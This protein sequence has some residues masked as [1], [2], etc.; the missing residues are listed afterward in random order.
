MEKLL[1]EQEAAEILG[2][3]VRTLKSWRY[4]ERRW[5]QGP[6]YSKVGR[7]VRYQSEALRAWLKANERTHT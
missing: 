3:S 6:P 7:G 5:V 4:G 2:V 1:T